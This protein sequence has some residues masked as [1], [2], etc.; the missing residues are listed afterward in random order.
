MSQCLIFGLDGATFTILDGLMETGVMPNLKRFAEEGAHGKLMSVKPPLTPPAWTTLVTGRT[1]GHHGVC[2]FFQYNSPE[3]SS[4]QIV[5]SRQVRAETMWAMVN[6][7]GKRSGCLNFV[8]HNP[9]PKID[10]WALPGWVSWRWMKSLSHPAGVV[11][12]LAAEIPGFDVKILA[13]DYEEERKAIVG[14]GI[15]DHEAWI[16][17]HISREKQ[18]FETLKRLQSTQPVDLAGI[19]FDGVDK[20]QHLLW[21]YLDP[22]IAPSNPSPEYQRT[23]AAALEYFRT[24]DLLLG[25]AM[26]LFR[27]WTILICSDHG[28]TNSWEI[29]FINMW[30]EQAGYLTWAAGTE[31]TENPAEMEPS[32]Y[33]LNAFDMDKTTAY[34]L[35]TSSNG[36]YINVKGKKGDFGI[37]PADYG[38]FRDELAARIANEIRDPA[39]GESIVTGIAT[40]EEAFHGPAMDLAPDLTLQLRD[41]GFVSV[42]RSNGI[43]ANRENPFGT[44]HP[45]GILFARGPGIRAGAKIEPTRLLDIAPTTLFAMGL[46]IPADLEGR[47]IEEL[48]EPAYLSEHAAKRGATTAAVQADTT[49]EV[50]DEDADILAK[51]QALGYLE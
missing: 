49:A 6:R 24:I 5:G 1:P 17:L 11:E 30:L 31:K 15:D 34:A 12:K 3:S 26:E 28:F 32:L 21:G 36:I 48:Y 22:R 46:D 51:M 44:H 47:V 7:Q 38:R 2:G 40:R 42:R 18:W 16:Q 20:L 10:G 29:L 13:M 43:L 23:R 9:A 41:F 45:E 39:T 37:D 33:H 19:V 27:D 8:A 35:T 25:E 4:I 14:S 50:P